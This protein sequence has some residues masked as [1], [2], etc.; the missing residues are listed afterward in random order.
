MFLHHAKKANVAKTHRYPQSQLQSDFLPLKFGSNELFW[1][2]KSCRR[3]WWP[4][5]EK[6]WNFSGTFH[7]FSEESK[8]NKIDAE[9]YQFFLLLWPID[10]LCV[11]CYLKGGWCTDATCCE[12]HCLHI[13]NMTFVETAKLP[14][15]VT[16]WVA[17]KQ[18]RESKR[19]AQIFIRLT[20]HFPEQRGQGRIGRKAWTILLP[21]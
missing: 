6:S 17:A 19:F 12:R 14:Q 9:G 1:P 7:S 15:N 13:G 5:V 2:Q 4:Q 16:Q 8:D 10:K 21:Q 11:I 3:S 18:P 20:L